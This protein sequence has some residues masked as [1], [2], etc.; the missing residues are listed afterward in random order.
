MKDNY[1]LRKEKVVPDELRREVKI[2]L[3]ETSLPHVRN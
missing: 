3:R 1:T 2:H